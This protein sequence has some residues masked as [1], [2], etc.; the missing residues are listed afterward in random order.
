[1]EYADGGDLAS[2]IHDVKQAGNTLSEDEIIDIFL[3]ICEGMKYCHDRKIVHRDIKSHNIFL[4]TKGEAKIGDFGIAK[5]LEHTQDNLQT[6][7]G[8]P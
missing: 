2:K 1:M 5:I 8:T 3:Q 4:T 7:V 6:L